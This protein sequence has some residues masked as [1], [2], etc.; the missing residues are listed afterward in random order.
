VQGRGAGG[1]CPVPPR[2]PVSTSSRSFAILLAARGLAFLD[3]VGDLRGVNFLA[4]SAR[5]HNTTYLCK[6]HP[7]RTAAAYTSRR[8][9]PAQQLAALSPFRGFLVRELSLH[10]ADEEEDLFP[11]LRRACEP[12]DGIGKVIER[13]TSD[14]DHAADDTPRVIADLDELLAAVGTPDEE[15]RAR[16]VRFCRAG[17]SASDPRERHN[18]ALRTLAPDGTGPGNPL[19]AHGA[20]PGRRPAAASEHVGLTRANSET[21]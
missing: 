14:H 7:L 18:P 11:L 19:S 3:C 1:R 17:A 4:W 5:Y 10:L 12:E 6:A 16:F 8:P 13:L 21:K 15:V 9:A 2:F 20:A